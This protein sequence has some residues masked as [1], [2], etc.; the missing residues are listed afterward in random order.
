MRRSR[1]TPRFSAGK[2]PAAVQTARSCESDSAS[3]LPSSCGRDG[4]QPQSWQAA[5][6]LFKIFTRK[7]AGHLGTDAFVAHTHRLP[8]A[9]GL[10]RG[11]AMSALGQKRT[12]LE[13]CAMSALP[14]KADIAGRRL[15]VRF[16][17]KADIERFHSSNSSARTSSANGTSI[18]RVLAV[19]RLTSSSTFV[20]CSTG[21]SAGLL[22]LRM[23]ST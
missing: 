6:G 11:S 5:C 17:P 10:C 15:D 22:P 19:C 2:W 4:C 9:V 1:K 7:A 21:S 18:P 16:V 3:M 13:V 12:F 14:P 23:R 20:G 8:V